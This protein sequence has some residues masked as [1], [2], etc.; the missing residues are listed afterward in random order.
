MI[1]G[2]KPHCDE[3]GKELEALAEEEAS[4]DLHGWS[5]WKTA[6][7]HLC[8]ICAEKK[9]PYIIPYETYFAEPDREVYH[10]STIT[11]TLEMR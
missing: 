8:Y 9:L 6:A 2:G 10:T 11:L 3:C 4:L 7:Y 5:D 1:K